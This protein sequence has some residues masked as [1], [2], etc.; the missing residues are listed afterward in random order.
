MKN[1]I[2]I[3]IGILISLPLI[4]FLQLRSTGAIALLMVICVSIIILFKTLINK[5]IKKNKD[6]LNDEEKNEDTDK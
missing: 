4:F 2:A 6:N 1:L 3:V 5:I